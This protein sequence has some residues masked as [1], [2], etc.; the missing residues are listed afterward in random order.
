MALGVTLELGVEGAAPSGP[1]QKIYLGKKVK[2][3]E[4]G[5]AQGSK[6]VCRGDGRA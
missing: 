4:T 2:C 5:A 6:L 1:F 3:V